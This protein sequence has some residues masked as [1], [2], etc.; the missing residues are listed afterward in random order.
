MR[1]SKFWIDKLDKL[2]S[3]KISRKKQKVKLGIF[4]KQ[5]AKEHEKLQILIN[6]LKKMDYFDIKT[7]EKPRDL[8]PLKFAKFYNDE[9]NSHQM[10]NW[11]DYILSARSTSV[12]IHA[13]M[14]KKKIFLLKY[15]YD[16]KK[17]SNLYKYKFIIKIDNESQITEL[18]NKKVK[19]LNKDRIKCLKEALV[20][21]QK[22]YMMLRLYNN[23]YSNL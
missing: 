17:Y 15:L 19:I 7:R 2:Y 1:Y 23:F 9:L 3:V 11:A 18:I 8:N 22:D 20:N 4:S 10:I 16:E 13:I 12:L 14:K 21:Y 5:Q 6:K